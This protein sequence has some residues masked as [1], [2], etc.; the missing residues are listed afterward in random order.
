MFDPLPPALGVPHENVVESFEATAKLLTLEVPGVGSVTVTVAPV[1]EWVTGKLEQS[2][3][4]V[5]R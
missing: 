5:L 3:I 1:V 2:P 4:A